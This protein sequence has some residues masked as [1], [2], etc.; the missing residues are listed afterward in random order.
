MHDVAGLPVG[1]A[2]AGLQRALRCTFLEY[3]STLCQRPASSFSSSS[4]RIRCAQQR[5]RPVAIDSCRLLHTTGILRCFSLQLLL[6]LPP[7]PL[8]L[9]PLLLLAL[10]LLPLRYPFLPPPDCVG[11][12]GAKLFRGSL[13][14][15][16]GLT[17]NLPR[18]TRSGTR[19]E[20][21]QEPEQAD[22]SVRGLPT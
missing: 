1:L 15:A 6:L 18:R 3:H 14:A 12:S 7:P 19:L 20:R 8:L 10:L 2:R 21:A 11:G 4:V 17:S 9:A 16:C 5:S 13:E 22:I